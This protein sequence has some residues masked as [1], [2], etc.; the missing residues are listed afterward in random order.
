MPT[1]GKAPPTSATRGPD[2]AT[3][4]LYKRFLDEFGKVSSEV[5]ISGPDEREG[6]D[7]VDQPEELN[8]ADKAKLVAFW[9]RMMAEHGGPEQYQ[10]NLINSFC[11]SE[12]PEIIIVVHKLLTGFDAPRNTVLYLCKPLKVTTRSCKRSP[13]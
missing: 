6:F 3:A 7:D 2:K 12:E 13:V 1:R 9:N 11:H 4:L 5:L 10:R 8:D